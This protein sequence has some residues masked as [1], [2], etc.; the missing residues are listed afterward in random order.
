M[1]A[2]FKSCPLCAMQIPVKAYVCPYCKKSIKTKPVTWLV[3]AAIVLM[4]LSLALPR[5]NKVSSNERQPAKDTARFMARNAALIFLKAPSTAKYCGEEIS[6]FDFAGAQAYKVEGCI[7]AQN[8][9]GAMLRN[10]YTAVIIKTDTGLKLVDV[11][12]NKP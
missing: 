12:F 1:N 4:L 3:L 9:F 2:Q 5:D 7:D 10:Y 6:E 11:N 8:S